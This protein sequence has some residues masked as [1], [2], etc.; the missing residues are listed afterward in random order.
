MRYLAG[1]CALAH[2]NRQFNGTTLAAQGEGDIDNST[3]LAHY[4]G[5]N[6]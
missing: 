2:A 1:E 4:E 5:R 3:A 6:L